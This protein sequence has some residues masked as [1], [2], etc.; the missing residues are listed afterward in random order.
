MIVCD[1]SFREG[2][3]RLTVPAGPGVLDGR[4]IQAA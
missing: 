4:K 1:M 2:Q 3:D